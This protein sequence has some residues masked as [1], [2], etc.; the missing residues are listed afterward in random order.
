MIKLK[1][2]LLERGMLSIFDFDDTLVTSDSWV[3]VK[4]PDGT[5]MQLDAA[6]FA[7][8]T[9][10]KGETFDFRDF[11][12]K[13][14]NPK[15]IKKNVDLLRKQL[16]K[17]GRKVTILTARRLGAPI[18][19]F[20]KTIG[21]RPYI[22]PLGDA[23]P[24]KKAEYIEDEIKKGYSPIYFMDDSKKNI[25]AVNKLKK[26]YPEVKFIDLSA[27]FRIQNANIYK[28]YYK[29]KHQAIK[30]IKKAIYSVAELSSKKIKKFRIISNPGCYPT[31]IQLPLI[32]LL[33]KKL[34][35]FNEITIDSK[36]GYSGAGKNYKDKFKFKNFYQAT[37]AYSV[38]NHR[39][40]AE[41]DQEL[42]KISK[43]IN[44]SFNPHL[45]PSFRGI[46]S[47]IYIT[48]NKNCSINKIIATL[49]KFY[50]KKYFIKINKKNTQLGT[51]NV[52][53]TNFCEIS[54][55]QTRSKNRLVIFSAI[56]NLVKGA[57]GQAI[58]NMNILFGINETKG[59]K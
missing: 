28:E 5:E 1:D 48:K 21:I 56:D 32:P 49:K 44:F 17:G 31:S 23:D 37:Y 35:K 25:D 29:Q 9:P 36:S 52:L 3:Y 54:V 22:V 11:D 38:T 7:V 16:S 8:Y 12:R 46:L 20:F 19:H 34:I 50:K 59:I 39:H 30:L 4:R 42:K 6:E 13:L 18:N 47:S 40:V 2:L 27:D 24:Q 51:G 58:Q 10:K 55:C 26:K 33:K 45:I 41:I 15:L 57:A 53:N 43:K 14:R